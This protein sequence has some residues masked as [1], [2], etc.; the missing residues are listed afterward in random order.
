MYD[1]KSNYLYVLDSFGKN[2]EY[3]KQLEEVFNS[4]MFSKVILNNK[5]QQ[6]QNT[7]TCNNWTFANIEAVKN[8]LNEGKI[9]DNSHELD[10]ILPKDINKILSEQKES[11]LNNLD[12]IPRH[13]RENI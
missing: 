10:S 13:I 5:K 8:K 7:Y 2:T 9:I 11:I 6:A 3:R 4:N 12:K 1:K